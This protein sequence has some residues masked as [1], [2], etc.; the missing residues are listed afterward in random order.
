LIS[1][2]AIKTAKQR[3]HKTNLTVLAAEKTMILPEKFRTIIAAHVL[4]HL[5]DPDE[6]LRQISI[7]LVKGGNFL[8]IVPNSDSWGHRIKGTKWIGYKDKTHI[9]LF[10]PQ[11]WRLL[12]DKNGFKIKS[13]FGDGLW[14][15]PYLPFIPVILQKI[16]FSLPA[17]LQTLSGVP[18]IPVK[19]GESVVFLARK[20]KNLF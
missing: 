7:V 14:D 9:S 11:Q 2:P 3:L 17:I 16:I 18:F 20:E 1:A 19:W 12:L 10:S 5:D 13:L 15:S 6:V 8:M 4:E